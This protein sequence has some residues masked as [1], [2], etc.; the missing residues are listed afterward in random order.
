MSDLVNDRLHTDTSYGT[1]P[2]TPTLPNSPG[3]ILVVPRGSFAS[4]TALR[5]HVDLDLDLVFPSNYRIETTG[6]IM[7]IEEA[8][9]GKDVSGNLVITKSGLALVL[10]Y[11]WLKLVH[12]PK[13][14]PTTVASPGAQPLAVTTLP[15]IKWLEI[16]QGKN[17]DTITRS[18]TGVMKFEKNNV[19]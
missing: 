1:D 16:G 9:G 13:G 4:R 18:I 11:I 6:K 3:R 5:G 12:N 7:T 17:L 15:D 2:K 19:C 14:T 8:L 10:R